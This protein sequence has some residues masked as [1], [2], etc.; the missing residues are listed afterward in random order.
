MATTI[1]HLCTKNQKI[2]MIQ[3]REKLVTDG[4]TNEHRLIVDINCLKGALGR[5]KNRSLHSAL[6]VKMRF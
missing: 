5:S 1:L 3:S 4:R 6:N 2:L